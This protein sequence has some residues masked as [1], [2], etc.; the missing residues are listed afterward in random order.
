MEFMGLAAWLLC[1]P[2]AETFKK[3]I[4]QRRARKLGIPGPPASPVH[5]WGYA[6]L[7]V[8]M[9]VARPLRMLFREPIVLLLSIYT[10]FVFGVLYAFFA[11]FPYVFGLE[12]GFNTWQSGLAFLGIGAGVVLGVVNSILCD[13]FIYQKLYR[14]AVA[15]GQTSLTPEHRLYAAMMGAVGLPIGYVV[16]FLFRFIPCVVMAC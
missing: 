3:V 12:Y 9:T 7:I 1:L 15:N 10:S 16:N 11:A 6:R 4:L 2:L 13:R 5:G 8:T 14:K